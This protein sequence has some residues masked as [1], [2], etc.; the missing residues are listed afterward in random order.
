MSFL[1]CS[2]LI[3]EILRVFTVGGNMNLLVECISTLLLHLLVMVKMINCISNL[4]TEKELLMQIESHRK[5]Y[6]S[7]PEVKVLNSYANRSRTITHVYIYYIYATTVMYMGTP[8]V[9]KILD[10]IL[11]LNES[12]P[13]IFLYEAEYFVDRSAYKTWIL[14]HSYVVTPLPATVVV[15][16]DSLYFHLA[17]HACSLFLIASKRMERLAQDMEFWKSSDQIISAKRDDV[18]DAV[19]LC[20]MQHMKAL[21]FADLLRTAYTKALFFILGINMLAMSITGF[22]T[23]TKLDEPSEAIR[24]GCYTIAQLIHL[25]FLSW[26]GQRLMDHS[27]RIHSAAYQGCWYNIPVHL[28]KLLILTMLRG[29][30]PSVL[31]AGGFYVMS[32]Q[33]FSLVLKTSASYF[34]IIKLITVRDDLQKIIA[35]VPILALHSLTITKMLNCLFSIEQNKL[36]LLEIQE[37]WQRNLSPGDVEILEK[38]ANQNRVITHTYIYY[39]YATTLMYLMGPM[40]PKVMDVLVPLN[41]SRPALEIYQT[42]YFVDPEKN[43]IPIL[44]HAYVITPFPSTIIVAFDALYCNYVNHACSM[45]EI[46]GKRLEA[47]I[48]DIDEI[49]HGLTPISEKSIHNSLKECIKQHRKSLQFAHLLRMTYSKCFLSIVIINTV[50]LSITGYQVV[51]NLGETSEILRYGTFSIGQIVHLFFLSRPAQKLMDQ[52]SRIHWSA[53]QGCWYRIPIRSKKMLILIMIRS[54][55]PSILT[56]GKLYVMSSQSF[57]RVVKT[58]MSYFTVLLSMR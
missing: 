54:G 38:N 45:F 20:I 25:Y 24:F 44:I 23:I 12:R 13:T 46:V 41:E 29:S 2:I 5:F 49:E 50:A 39:I 43:E 53:Y 6:S 37:D 1:I 22:Q 58:S 48:N 17:E 28:Q 15:A 40:V 21:K 7:A 26:P 11:P 18:G 10:S 30:K 32:L 8:M 57:A 56:A 34:T 27:Q 31:T 4:E 3:P 52:S 19:V 35:C 51:A 16:F 42:E 33:S 36:L 47:I 9:P 14:L 55:K